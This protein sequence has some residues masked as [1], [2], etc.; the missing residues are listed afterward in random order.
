MEGETEVCGQTGYRTQDLW[1]TSQI[2]YRLRYAARPPKC[3][4]YLQPTLTNV[5]NGTCTPKGDQRCQIILKSMH[6]CRR[7]GPEKLNLWPF[8]IWPLSGT[9]TFNLPEQMFQMALLLFKKISC[10]KWFWIPRK[11]INP[12][13]HTQ[14]ARTM[15]RTNSKLRLLQFCL[16]NQTRVR[17]K[18]FTFKKCI[19]KESFIKLSIFWTNTYVCLFITT[20]T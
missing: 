6:K 5:S 17:P 3:D 7:Y 2:P 14:D 20:P 1:L 13:G 9:L 18:C 15:Q 16:I 11:K 12:D 19:R 4:T 10:A 8:I